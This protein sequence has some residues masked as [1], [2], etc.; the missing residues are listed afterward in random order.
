MLFSDV[1][2]DVVLCV[3]FFS[4][5]FCFRMCIFICVP[6][7]VC[8]CMC[9]VLWCFPMEFLICSYAG[10]AC[11]LVYVFRPACVLYCFL[12]CFPMCRYIVICCGHMLFSYDYFP[13]FFPMSCSRCVLPMFVFRYVLLCVFHICEVRWL[14]YYVV[15]QMF[16]FF[17]CACPYAVFL[18]VCF[19]YMTYHTCFFICVVPAGVRFFISCFHMKCPVCVF[20]YVFPTCV[21]Y[22]CVGCCFHMRLSHAVLSVWCSLPSVPFV[23]VFLCVLYICLFHMLFSRLSF[24]YIFVLYA[25]AIGVFPYECAIRCDYSI[26][27]MCPS[28]VLFIWVVSDVCWR[29]SS[30]KCMCYMECYCVCVF[31]LCVHS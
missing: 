14:M 2:T 22:A 7:N 24:P 13:T 26:R 28:D 18:R 23:F 25:L 20:I 27:H 3:C 11:A 17:R 30:A 15:Y 21:V 1:C 19:V 4:T 16:F 8:A 6:C 10:G 31:F 29:V 5:C 12:C 9:A